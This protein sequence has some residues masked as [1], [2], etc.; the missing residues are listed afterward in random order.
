MSLLL[1]A[2]RPGPS[3]GGRS[4]ALKRWTV[5]EFHDLGERGVFEGQ[6]ASLIEGQIF[7]EGPM[8]PPHAVACTKLLY[9][10][11]RVVPIEQ[12]HVRTSMPLV[13][14]KRTDPMPDLAVIIGQ[15]E[16]YKEHP[17]HAELVVEISDT[18]FYH[19]TGEKMSLYASAGIADYWVLDINDRQLI[20]HRNPVVDTEQP[21]GYRYADVKRYLTGDTVS[22]LVLSDAKIP[23]KDMLPS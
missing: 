1:D 15:P 12:Y 19:D 2:P 8:N 7:E 22:P 13:F 4:P 11:M 23:V 21:F 5:K 14:G 9:I 20:V 17:N 3:T 18:S 6:R 10:L 16:D